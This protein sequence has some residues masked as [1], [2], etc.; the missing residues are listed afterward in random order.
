MGAGVC[1]PPI[2]YRIKGVQYVAVG[3]AGCHGGEI[4][5]HNDGRPIF[6]DVFAIFALPED[7]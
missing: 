3:A 1:T 5:M 2:T 4:L 6:G 7:K